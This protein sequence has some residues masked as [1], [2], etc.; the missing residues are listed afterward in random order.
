LQNRFLI[1]TNFFEAIDMRN[2]STTSPALR[3]TGSTPGA[4]VR[5][6]SKRGGFT[7]VEIL[8]ALAVMVVMLSI[9][10]V[11]INMGLSV[12][13]I[14][15]AR[16]EVQQANQL[17]LNQLTAEL[18]RAVHVFPN[19]EMPGITS[20]VPYSLVP[21]V[22]ESPYYD[23]T[24]STRADNT[25]RLDFLLPATNGGTI[26]TPPQA[27][28][29]IVTYY[30]RRLDDTK[31]YDIFSNPVVLWRAQ[32]P[33]SPDPSGAALS[34]PANLTNTRYSDWSL[35][36]NKWLVQ[37]NGEP[38]LAPSP[39]MS[40]PNF[41][42]Q[43]VNSASAA[44]HTQITP[45]DMALVVPNPSATLQPNSSFICDDANND[46]KIDRVTISLLLQKYDS[47][48]AADDKS[49]QIRS[50]QTVALPNVK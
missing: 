7:L 36:E 6:R 47:L 35:D 21:A 23:N 18:K 48:G 34:T 26:L 20:K 5:T 10:L 13:H 9:I 32:Y 46:G 2:S 27:G 12:F 39:S 45:R 19:E 3:R 30:A 31:A 11:P 14:G 44:S 8:V 50:T 16:S 42:V 15:K 38:N 17:V 25:A 37:Y 43:P 40:I 49:Q 24:T 22:A 41:C 1:C 4:G 29:Y 28:N 33:Y